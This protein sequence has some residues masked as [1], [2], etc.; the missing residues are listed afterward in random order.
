VRPASVEPAFAGGFILL[1]V[2]DAAHASILRL[3]PA[4]FFCD[5]ILAAAG[6]SGRFLFE[7]F[8]FPVKPVKLSGD[9]L[10]RLAS[11]IFRTFE[12]GD[13]F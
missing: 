10:D 9:Q 7:G 4:Q 5:F 6:S 8:D 1:A 2:E 13:Q 11:R 12:C 3:E